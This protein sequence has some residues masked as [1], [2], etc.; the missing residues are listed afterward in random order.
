ML[1]I[2]QIQTWLQNQ[3][4]FD[5]KNRK[6]STK[7]EIYLLNSNIRSKSLGLKIL[8][9]LVKNIFICGFQN[10]WKIS[11]I[12]KNMRDMKMKQK[13]KMRCFMFSLRLCSL[14]VHWI[15]LYLESRVSVDGGYERLLQD[16][17]GHLQPTVEVPQHL[18]SR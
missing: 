13:D 12:S 11:I 7:F 9:F 14:K 1:L 10:V 3:Q 8:K 16:A 6:S 15:T 2:F 4:K 5:I 17:V 18:C